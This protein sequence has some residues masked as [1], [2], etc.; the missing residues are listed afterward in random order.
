MPRPVGSLTSDKAKSLQ[1]ARRLVK[2]LEK[3][4]EAK[5]KFS[6]AQK[7]FEKRQ[8]GVQAAEACYTNGESQSIVAVLGAALAHPPLRV[9]PG[10][11]S[12]NS[13]PVS[14]SGGSLAVGLSVASGG[15][16][17]SQLGSNGPNATVLPN[18]TPR[19]AGS[20]AV[21]LG[22]ASENSADSRFGSSEPNAAPLR[23]SAPL[24]STNRSHR[25]SLDPAHPTLPPFVASK[26]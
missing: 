18:S 16:A 26:K 17:E 21:G 9:S 12:S 4:A 5:K 2:S 19:V 22:A 24:N 14:R 3:E 6:K 25:A 1:V 15:S 7:A 10:G 11:A 13:A 8:N 23:N 20:L